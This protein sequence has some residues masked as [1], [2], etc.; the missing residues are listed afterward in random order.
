MLPD[1]DQDISSGHAEQEE[2]QAEIRANTSS[3]MAVST[4][5]HL[6][7]TLIEDHAS[8]KKLSNVLASCAANQAEPEAKDM[9]GVPSTPS[10]TK[11][12]HATSPAATSHTDL[13]SLNKRKKKRS[14]KS[15]SH[16]GRGRKAKAV[17]S[18]APRNVFPAVKEDSSALP[19]VPPSHGSVKPTPL[20]L[21]IKLMRNKKDY[22]RRKTQRAEQAVEHL[23]DELLTACTNIAF[24]E[25]TNKRDSL[26]VSNLKATA[27]NSALLLARRTDDLWPIERGRRKRLK[28]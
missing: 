14:N 20:A 13:P 10:P 11:L 19:P 16:H 28:V 9:E 24:L 1:G 12:P 21:Q 15:L 22:E 3:T 2:H 25:M 26:E 4:L 27:E 5:Q 18:E 6:T 7:N 17:K 23:K 8:A